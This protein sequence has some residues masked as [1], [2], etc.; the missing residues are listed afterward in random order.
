M[1]KKSLFP[2]L[3][4]APRKVLVTKIGF[5]G[6]DRSGLIVAAC[7]RDAGMEVIARPLDQSCSE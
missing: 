3:L 4:A 6:H 5:A 2:M 7:L 1:L